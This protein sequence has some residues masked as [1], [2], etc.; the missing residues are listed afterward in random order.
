MR[1]LLFLLTTALVISPC[2]AS[3]DEPLPAPKPLAPAARSELMHRD[4]SVAAWRRRDTKLIIGGL[5]MIPVG[6]AALIGG[7]AL[8][9]SSDARSSRCEVPM[10]DG[11]L[12][13]NLAAGV[14]GLGCAVDKGYDFA[15]NHFFGYLLVGAGGTM[16]AAGGIM[17]IAGAS[18]V[19]A[20][21]GTLRP[22][23]S[24]GPGSVSLKWS[25]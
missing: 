17:A 7:I 10:R 19:P 24:M 9:E 21:P 13:G 18:W 23:V 12:G 15:G 11:T 1:T 16:V 5:A 6:I 22:A 20:K 2:I 25:F 4:T 14:A 8:V 3:A